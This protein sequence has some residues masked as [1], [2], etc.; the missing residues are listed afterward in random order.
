[1]RFTFTA[2]AERALA[3]ASDWCSRTGREELDAE[4]LLVGLLSESECRAAV[5]LAKQGVDTAAVCRQWPTLVP[6]PAEISQ[7]NGGD[8]PAVDLPHGGGSRRIPFSLEVEDSLQAACDRLD[9]LPRRPEL[10]TEHVLLGL[11]SADHEVAIWLRQCGLDS[12]AIETEIRGLYGYAILPEA[13]ESEGP[14]SAGPDNE[15]E[16]SMYERFT[17]R[18]RKIMQLANQEAQRFN[19]EYIGTEHILLG[20]IKEGSGVG[21]NVLK[22][23]DVDLRKVRMEVEKL[24]QSGPDKVTTGKLPQTPRAKKVIEY[25][26]EEARNLNHNYVGTEHI[27]LGLLREQE[28]VAAQVLVNLGLKL[29]GVREEVLNLLGHGMEGPHGTDRPVRLPIA[30]ISPTGPAATTRANDILRVLDAAANRAREGLRVVEDYVRFLL[31]DQ[32]LTELCKQL[33]HDLTAATSQISADRRMAAR[34]TQD[35]VGTMLTTSTERS[36]DDVTGVVRANFAR[37]QESL[38]S[39]EEFSKL[40]NAAWTG[41]NVLIP[42]DAG[43]RPCRSPSPGQRPGETG[44]IEAMSSAQRANRSETVAPLGR[45][46]GEIAP[47]SQGVALG[48]ANEAPSGRTEQRQELSPRPAE[49]SESFK[50]LRYRTYTLERAV[51]ITHGSIKRM[52]KVRLYVLIDGRG[53]PAEFERLVVSLIQAGVHAIQLRDKQLAD[54]ELLARARLLRALTWETAALCIINDRPDL[55]A[56]AGAD[57]VHIGQEEI[58]VKD[59]RQIV[60]ATALVGVSTHSIEQARQAVL[61]GA[62]Y[63]GVGP[64]FPSGTKTFEQFPGL[65]LLRAVAAEIRL[66]AFA[67]GGIAKENIGDVLATGFT[68]VAVS[69]AVAAAADP[70]EAARQLLAVLNA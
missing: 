4:S 16:K 38:R 46:F 60:G 58:S 29:E 59:A 20:L 45:E 69:G 47:S 51:E 57:G 11:V 1:M 2:A 32:H 31:D 64:T 65:D 54:R 23:L 48:W 55:A 63:I 14:G 6:P 53:S 13:P 3:L 43:R 19:H 8:S 7:E 50:Q 34:E 28:G 62:N 36:R 24:V 25:S 35:D 70:A 42:A 9:Y 44:E 27:L 30:P 33:R 68:R 40:W 21:A 39:L 49:L 10:A 22:N 17:D 18:A 12:D 61:D 66:P 5:M 26:M 56:L 67:I 52:P 37:L 41:K 15:R